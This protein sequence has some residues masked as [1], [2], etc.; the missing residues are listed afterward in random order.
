MTYG[1]GEYED[2]TYDNLDRLVKVTYNGSA[3]NAFTVLYDSNGRLAK[4]VDGK[5]DI[6]ENGYPKKIGIIAWFDFILHI[7]RDIVRLNATK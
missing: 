7:M 6:R 5:V 4:A 1:N 3:E 2:Y